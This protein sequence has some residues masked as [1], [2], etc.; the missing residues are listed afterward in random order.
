M[1][2]KVR[3]SNRILKSL[4]GENAMTVLIVDDEPAYRL[5]ARD[6]LIAAGHDVLLAANGEE[7]LR[8]L[9]IIEPDIIVSDVYMPVMDGR[10]LHRAV[11]EMPRFEKLPFL[12]VSGYSDEET[13]GSVRD[14]RYEGFLS[15]SSSPKDLLEWVNYLTTP[16]DKRG[17]SFPGLP[18]RV[19]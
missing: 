1:R 3:R 18:S 19:S 15:K 13:L 7:A 5:A 11:R 14:P 16:P 10:K 12:F 17:Q 8:K 2:V 4:L 6:L 9:S